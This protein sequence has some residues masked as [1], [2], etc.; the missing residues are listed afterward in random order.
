MAAYRSAAGT[1]EGASAGQRAIQPPTLPAVSPKV[2]LAPTFGDDLSGV[3]V[4]VART[5]RLAQH[6]PAETS[7]TDV[8]I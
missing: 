7:A 2:N 6:G 8:P 5:A 4:C 1:Y 3:C